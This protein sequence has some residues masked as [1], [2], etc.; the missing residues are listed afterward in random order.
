M[1][2]QEFLNSY[3]G[4]SFPVLTKSP[5]YSEDHPMRYRIMD[6]VF[7]RLCVEVTHVL[8]LSDVDFE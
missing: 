8:L 3:K 2:K 6:A 4:D 7:V 5:I 1:T